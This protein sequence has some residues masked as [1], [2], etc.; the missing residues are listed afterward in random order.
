MHKFRLENNWLES[1]FKEKDTG[2]QEYK[3]N[4]SKQ[5]ALAAKYPDLC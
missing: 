5:L 2:V 4:T 1:S 3:L